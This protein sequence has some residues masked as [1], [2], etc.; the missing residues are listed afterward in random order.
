MVT[1]VSESPPRIVSPARQI[2]TTSASELMRSA[3]GPLSGDVVPASPLQSRSDQGTKGSSAR[4]AERS[5][6]PPPS[7]KK[8][9]VGK[10]SCSAERLSYS[11]SAGAIGRMFR[12]ATATCAAREEFQLRPEF[13]SSAG[14]SRSNSVSSVHSEA[15]RST[16]EQMDSMVQNAQP[17]VP[18]T[19]SCSS[20]VG[21]VLTSNV[22]ATVVQNLIPSRRSSAFSMAEGSDTPSC[23]STS[24]QRVRSS[25]P[26][27]VVRTVL[28]PA[29]SSAPVV[30]REVGLIAGSASSAIVQGLSSPGL[31]QLVSPTSS[32]RSDTRNSSSERHGPALRVNAINSSANIPDTIDES[33]NAESLVGDWMPY[34][35]R[36][37]SQGSL[38]SETTDDTGKH[39]SAGCAESVENSRMSRD[40]ER[41]EVL[42]KDNEM[43]QRRWLARYCEKLQK[44]DDDVKQ[45]FDH[46]KTNRPYDRKN[47]N[48]WY[49]NNTNRYFQADAARR[50]Q[51]VSQEEKRLNQELAECQAPQIAAKKSVRAG[52]SKNH[53]QKRQVVEELIAAQA[54]AAEA[55]VALDE[56]S[57][58]ER[59]S[60]EKQ[61]AEDL[62]TA[63]EDNQRRIERFVKTDDGREMM[64]ERAFKYKE[65][66]EGLDDA[67]AL[68]EA[69]ED[70]MRASEEKVRA[71]T[72][73][74]FRGQTRNDE[75]RIQLER[76]QVLRELIHLQKQ[77]E[78]IISDETA[79]WLQ[80]FDPDLVSRIKQEA[81][82]REAR[83][84]AERLVRAEAEIA[85]EKAATE[86]ARPKPQQQAKI[87]R[88]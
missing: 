76:L 38:R 23:S 40:S 17:Q 70:L 12:A 78:D 48:N 24:G 6:R 9:S 3:L 87:F 29:G 77:Y 8:S 74:A 67:S 82:Y 36:L 14:L 13:Y 58:A 26:C 65:L 53:H 60:R 51:H 45:L 52:K 19:P 49:S 39:A 41:F 68:K 34:P 71:D 22:S 81:W 62:K 31:S 44:E 69:Q 32:Q 83:D 73:L 18:R 1:T 20:T 63:L 85:A 88:I 28:S 80:S 75:H 86:N 10:R 84:A 64:A 66:N 79:T 4:F 16:A 27:A 7:S 35:Q 30:Y 5:G 42:Y 37:R 50:E 61:S 57:Q 56:R 15:R 33:L 72:A 46:S 59:A 25:S 47:F 2:A 21:Q 54:V 55:L 43:R 11:D